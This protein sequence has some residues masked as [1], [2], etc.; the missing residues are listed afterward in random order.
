MDTDINEDLLDLY[1]V[2]DNMLDIP[3]FSPKS[4]KS[5]GNLLITIAIIVLT[6]FVVNL[7]A[8]SPSE[9]VKL[10]RDSFGSKHSRKGTPSRI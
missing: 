1:N 9:K 2:S 4:R 6:I 7:F 3:D 8:L 5:R 10:G